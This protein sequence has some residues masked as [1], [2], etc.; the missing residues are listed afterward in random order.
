MRSF[1]CP[2][3]NGLM[4]EIHCQNVY[5]EG[6]GSLH[7]Q[8]WYAV[9]FGK[10]LVP[11]YSI[12]KSSICF[13]LQVDNS[14]N[15][16]IT[17]LDNTTVSSRH[18]GNRD[19]R[20]DNLIL[21]LHT[22]AQ[23]KAQLPKTFLIILFEGTLCCACGGCFRGVRVK[24]VHCGPELFY[25]MMRRNLHE[26]NEQSFIRAEDVEMPKV[27]SPNPIIDLKRSGNA[28]KRI[29]Y[30]LTAR[31]MIKCIIFTFRHNYLC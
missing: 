4:L 1:I 22:I 19:T 27:I 26:L 15:E 17:Y 3:P 12:S 23:N 5:V 31:L 18:K 8:H 20:T 28:G 11:V 21:V 14:E 7:D 29:G 2:Q 25:Y 9:L 24:E 13:F 30:K 10:H 16:F 6:H